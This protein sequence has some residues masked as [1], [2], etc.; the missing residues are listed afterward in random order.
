MMHYPLIFIGAFHLE[1]YLA[2]YTHFHHILC[3]L[4][5]MSLCV[6]MLFFR[7]SCDYI[8]EQL[9]AAINRN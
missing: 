4:H 2:G 7:V 1:R 3:P 9:I 8:S 5:Y 6:L